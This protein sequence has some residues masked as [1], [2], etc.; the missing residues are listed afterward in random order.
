[1]S[2][3]KP[4][5]TYA[6]VMATVAVFLGLTGGAVAALKIPKKSVGTKQLKAKA[7]TGPKIADSAVGGGK[8]ADSAV[9]A[10]KI[11][12]AAVASAKVQDHSLGL[13][14]T[15]V[16][17]TTVTH[18]FPSV[19][20]NNCFSVTKAVPAIVQRD[21]LVVVVPDS[22]ALIGGSSAWY[23]LSLTASGGPFRLAPD[24][25]ISLRACS[26]T[27]GLDPPDTSFRVL[28]FR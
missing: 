14:D 5:L 25:L 15:T 18:D 4:R 8:I 23:E 27:G 1:M 6:N 9:D 13:V 16:L 17:D 19:A 3:L 28:V 20:A 21:D 10:S 7:V 11:A 22:N 2:K 26:L 24:D 12:D